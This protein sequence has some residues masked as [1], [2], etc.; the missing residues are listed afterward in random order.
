MGYKSRWR[1]ELIR[2]G[3]VSCLI[4]Y[5]PTP[6]GGDIRMS[7]L[8]RAEIYLYR[9]KRDCE[10]IEELKQ[11][12]ADIE[13]HGDLKVNEIRDM[14][15]SERIRKGVEDWYI[16]CEILSERIREL[17]RRVGKIRELREYMRE[18][19][20]YWLRY[21]MMSDILERVYIGKQEFAL[22]IK[23]RGISER[24]AYRRRNELL[25]ITCEFLGL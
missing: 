25:E 5:H 19:G 11:R 15:R 17:T 6:N 1:E 9:Y 2:V 22:F 14:P 18:S 13:Y 20:R 23:E 4:P 7:K 8:S 21:A 12:L 16:S 24:T 10:R 3:D